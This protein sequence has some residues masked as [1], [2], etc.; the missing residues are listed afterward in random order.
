MV[1]LQKAQGEKALGQI[2]N[3]LAVFGYY[4]SPDV[5]ARHQ[6]TYDSIKLALKAFEIECYNETGRSITD[7]MKSRW[8]I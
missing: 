2:Q 8:D 4:D 7:E 3:F 5:K 6:A 1:E